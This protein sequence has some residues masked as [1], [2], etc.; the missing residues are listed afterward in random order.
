MKKIDASLILGLIFALIIGNMNC[1]ARECENVSTKVLRLHILANSD[2]ESDQK[3]KL[4]VRDSILNKTADSLVADNIK[5]A[6]RIAK[7][8]LD[9][10][11]GIAEKTVKENGYD[12][13][14][15]VEFVN[16]FFDTRYYDDVT[17][18]AGNYDAVRVTIGKGEGHNWWC[19]LYP[20]LCVSPA[21]AED[22]DEISVC[23][24]PKI[25]AKFKI[26]EWY[27]ETKNFISN[28]FSENT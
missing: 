3:L 17:M 15:S 10:I 21:I 27:Q 8:S 24:E 19:V 14:V 7:M 11:K 4:K 5:S 25:K 23:T 28:L 9:D 18:P 1:F 6:E 16:M 22:Y 12:Y 2:S 13:S 20:P 26:Y